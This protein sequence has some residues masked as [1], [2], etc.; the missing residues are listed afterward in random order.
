VAQLVP[1]AGLL[2]H[3]ITEIYWQHLLPDPNYQRHLATRYQLVLADDV[4][5]YPAIAR[6]SDFLLDQGAVERLLIILM[7]RCDSDLSDP[8]YLQGLA[9]RCQVEDLAQPALR[10]LVD[11]LS[12]CRW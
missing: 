8:N 4:D 1:G 11:T 9:A 10:S 6:C 2:T 7:V 3:G 5:D 12:C